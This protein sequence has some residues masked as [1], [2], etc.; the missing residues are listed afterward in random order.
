MGKLANSLHITLGSAISERGCRLAAPLLGL[1]LTISAGACSSTSASFG[2][3]RG[4]YTGPVRLELGTSTAR[5]GTLVTVNSKGRW[6]SHNVTTGNYGLLG[7]NKD[8]RFVPVYNI[9]AI[10]PG[11]PRGQNFPYGSPEGIG[12]VGL[13]DRQFRIRVPPV[14][15]GT[16]IVQ[17][18][19]SVAPTTNGGGPRQYNLCASLHVIG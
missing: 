18:S 8:N 10:A 3:P 13:P 17:F 11:I 4:C 5:P 6:P 12:G 9:A 14:S 16:Y 19:Y 15:N 7:I 2:S 1:A